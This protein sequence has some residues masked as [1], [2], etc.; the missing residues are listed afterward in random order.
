MKRTMKLF[1]ALFLAGCAASLVFAQPAKKTVAV[2]VRNDSPNY[3]QELNANKKNLENVVSSY[4]NNS[5]FGV[6]SADLVLRNINDY[7][8]NENAKYKDV[9]EN[10]KSSISTG[11][12]LDMKLFENASGLRLAEMIGAD[13]IL[14]VSISNFSETR[15]ASNLYGAKTVNQIYSL[16]CNYNLCEGGMGVGTSG[17]SV[18]SQKMI[19]QTEGMVTEKDEALFSELLDDCA[20]QMA[21]AISSDL[22]ENKIIAKQDAKTDVIFEVRVTAMRFPQIFKEVDGSYAIEESLVPLE[23]MTI[24]ADIDGVSYTTNTGAI[25]LSKGIHYLKINHK[26][27]EP[28]EK[29][30]NVTG[31]PGQRFVYEG[32]LTAAAKQRLQADMEWMQK[33]VEK[34][35]ASINQDKTREIDLERRVIQARSEAADVDIK[36]KKAET[37]IARMQS[38]IDIEKSRARAEV[39]RIDSR[40]RIET[41]MADAEIRDMDSRAADRS[42]LTDAHVKMS[43]AEGRAKINMSEAELERAKG[44][45]EALK[46]SGFKINANVNID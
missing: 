32:I 36:I 7:L 39:A 37:Q 10:I 35:K 27:L 43:D 11:S 28:I 15:K 33:T 45:Y 13:Y 4:L 24:N 3:T 34:Y 5:G 26:D 17:R 29:T 8:G 2:F 19:R 16:R 9:A 30:I 12:K 41:K 40:T 25:S 23:L 20:M 18:K 42:K 6:I 31:E 46:R 22:A 1:S 14:V 44:I 21:E 38:E